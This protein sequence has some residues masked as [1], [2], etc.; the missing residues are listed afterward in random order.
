MDRVIVFLFATRKTRSH[1]KTLGKGTG[2]KV[3]ELAG[4]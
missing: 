4:L 1:F 2:I 3:E